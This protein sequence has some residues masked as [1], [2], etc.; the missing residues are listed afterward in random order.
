MLLVKAMMF[1]IEYEIIPNMNAWTAHIIAKSADEATAY[2]QRFVR[3]EIRVTSCGMVATVDAI[4]PS[5]MPMLGSSAAKQAKPPGL[6]PMPPKEEKKE[7]INPPAPRMRTS[8]I[9]KK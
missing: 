8:I 7:E 2:I 3:R 1:R 6:P 4:T 9:S 5:V